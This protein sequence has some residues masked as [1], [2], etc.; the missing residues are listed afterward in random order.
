[1]LEREGTEGKGA[2]EIGE[3]HPSR[4]PLDRC[5][6]NLI[7]LTTSLDC[8][9]AVSPRTAFRPR[10][11]LYDARRLS[12]RTFLPRRPLCSRPPTAHRSLARRLLVPQHVP[13]HV[14]VPLRPLDPRRPGSLY[15]TGSKRCARI[16]VDGCRLAGGPGRS[17]I[18]ALCRTAMRS[19]DEA[20]RIKRRAYRRPFHHN[21]S[22]PTFVTLM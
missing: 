6:G 15:S 14:D 4:S 22:T 20:D 12:A 1:M 8:A 19:D 2:Q 5:V 18:Q 10:L 3:L 21:G 17:G 13:P 16:A 9:S 11:Q 7:V